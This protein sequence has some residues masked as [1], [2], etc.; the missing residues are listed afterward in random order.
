MLTNQIDLM[1]SLLDGLYEEADE[2]I[3]QARKLGKVGFEYCDY[4]NRKEWDSKPFS[5]YEKK[6]AD[7][8]MEWITEY[9]RN[10]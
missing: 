2:L 8:F 7:Q 4:C 3:K 6:I 1:H 5:S 10:L 9:Q